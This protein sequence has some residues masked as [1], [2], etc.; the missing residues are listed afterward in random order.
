VS[1]R[2]ASAGEFLL[3][4]F[5][6]LGGG[7]VVA[8]A[9]DLALT[10]LSVAKFAFIL[11]GFTLLI[12]TMALKNPKAFWLFLLALS[13]P[14][15]ISKMLS[16]GLVDPQSLV[17]SY[18]MPASG[19]V[20][21]EL[22]L[23]DVVLLAMLPPWLARVCMRQQSFYFPSIGYLFLFYLVWALLVSLINAE[24]F[25]LSIV[26]L[27]RQA[28]YFLT[29][30]YLINNVAT[31]LQFRTVVVAVFVGFIIGA[32]SVITFFE[33]GIGTDYIAFASLR[34]QS[35]TSEKSPLTAKP[36]KTPVTQNLTVSNTQGNLSEYRGH[37]SAIKRSQGIFR[38]PAVAA[39]WCGLCLPLVLAYLVAARK[40]RDRILF[41]TVF[42]FGI[43]GLVL[44]F[45][46]AG[47]IGFMVGTLVCVAVGGWSGLI[48]RRVLVVSAGILT[49]AAALSLPFLVA[50]L[51]ARE[52]SYSM[53]FDLFWAV[54]QGYW[55]HPILGVGLNN[56]TAAMKTGRQV[57]RDLGV[58]IPAW[59]SADNHYLALLTDLGPLGFILFFAFFAKIVMIALRAMREVAPDMKPLLVGIVGGLASLA[60]QDLADDALAPHAISAMVWLFAALIVASARYCCPASRSSASTS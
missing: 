39:S 37:G 49:L 22:Y 21:L 31:R 9:T 41:L 44:T 6:I 23:T 50:Y 30:V 60:T 48:P 13:T 42:F 58:K 35:V 55:E 4:G 46:R 12:P 2:S 38:H 26:E 32:G 5:G 47:L 18:G 53:R 17:D 56:S 28:L 7:V 15:D 8:L 24:S 10:Q 52:E 54:L 1:V 20:S 36:G 25:Y 33:M 19:T 16:S 14:F 34:D 11:G 45:S 43:T 57:L 3:S 51:T 59:E 27:G 29:F 40:N